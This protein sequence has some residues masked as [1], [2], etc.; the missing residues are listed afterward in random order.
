MIKPAFVMPQVPEWVP[1][2]IK[3]MIVS[4]RLR[5]FETDAVLS[6]FHMI[7]APR[8]IREKPKIREARLALARELIRRN[9]IFW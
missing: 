5:R 1:R 4:L 8:S 6:A 3:R 7:D 2:R 9:V